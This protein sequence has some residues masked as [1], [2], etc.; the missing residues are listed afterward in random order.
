MF[1]LQQKEDSPFYNH[2]TSFTIDNVKTTYK[3]EGHKTAEATYNGKTIIYKKN[4]QTITQ[5]EFDSAWKIQGGCPKRHADCAFFTK[6]PDTSTGGDYPV[7]ELKIKDGLAYSCKNQGEQI[8]KGKIVHYFSPT[9]T[10]T[11]A[12][13]AL[14]AFIYLWKS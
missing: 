6:E 13:V 9:L 4:G 10:G 14:V 2:W 5:G 7:G 8:A 12:A 1:K 3:C 11:I